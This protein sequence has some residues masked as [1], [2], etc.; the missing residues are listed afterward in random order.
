MH[1]RAA[2]LFVSY[3]AFLMHGIL[4]AK[5]RYEQ[6][7]RVCGMLFLWWQ[8]DFHM[9]D[10]LPRSSISFHGFSVQAHF[11]TSLSENAVLL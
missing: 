10:A 9:T 6:G 4:A 5:E 11:I 2:I 8:V 1:C 3:W 7:R